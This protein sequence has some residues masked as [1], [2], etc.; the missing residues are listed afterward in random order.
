MEKSKFDR[1]PRL[2]ITGL[3]LTGLV[4]VIFI[5]ELSLRFISPIAVSNVGF[6]DTINGK[7]YGWGFNPNALVRIEDP[8]TGKV[9]QDNVN[10]RGWRDRSRS[11]INKKN[12]FRILVLGD[13]LTFGFIVPRTGTF[14]QL[15]ENKF[16][17]RNLN[18]EVINISYSGWSTSQQLEALKLEGVLYKPDV[19]LVH[20]CINDLDENFRYEDPGKFGN[21]VPFYHQISKNNKLVRRTNAR[22]V[23]EQKA[24]TRKY[25]ISKSEILKRLWLANL[26]FKH[27]TQP[28]YDISLNKINQIK[29]IL[30][31]KFPKHLDRELIKLNR[32][33]FQASEINKLLS[34]FNLSK[35]SI[36]VVLRLLENRPF[37]KE[38]VA[39]AENKPNNFS[40]RRWLLYE[41]II[42]EMQNVCES[43]GC[44]LAIS[45]DHGKGRYKWQKEW[46]ITKDDDISRR[47]FFS[48]NK[49]LGRIADKLGIGFLAA[50]R[51]SPRARN[52]SHINLEGNE[53]LAD[54]L[55]NFFMFKYKNRFKDL[56]QTP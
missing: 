32:T 18:V 29:H 39:G 10:N 38:I 31:N 6:V 48:I 55:F 23:L 44:S 51:G 8:D 11:L 54:E 2:T 14:T 50:K 41:A 16:L 27:Q 28:P 1:Y 49:N 5:L 17:K 20:F 40:D 9:T 22:F 26:S 37:L 25:L 47:N 33:N 12:S 3:I 46:Y 19:V 35:N 43:I 15:L 42:R 4:L 45:S 24:I 7:T 53:V 21:R 30:D 52:D 56:N 13:S 36:S 34:K